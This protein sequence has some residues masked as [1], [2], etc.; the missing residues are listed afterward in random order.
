MGKL[1]ITSMD[2]INP[3]HQKEHKLY[4]LFKYEV[5]DGREKYEVVSPDEGN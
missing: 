1:I 3:N 5:T 2:R 4:E